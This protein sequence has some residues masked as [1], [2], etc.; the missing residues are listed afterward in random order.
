MERFDEA[1]A[2]LD[3]NFSDEEI[4]FLEEPYQA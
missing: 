2:A 3:V 1:V 4:E